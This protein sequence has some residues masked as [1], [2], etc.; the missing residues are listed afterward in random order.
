MLLSSHW[1]STTSRSFDL[2]A[3]YRSQ[4]KILFRILINETRK[5]EKELVQTVWFIVAQHFSFDS[6]RF[7]IHTRSFQHPKSVPN[8][9]LRHFTAKN[10]RSIR[11]SA[12]CSCT[13]YHSC[14]SRC[15]F[16]C[17]FPFH[18]SLHRKHTHSIAAWCLSCRRLVLCWSLA[19]MHAYIHT[20]GNA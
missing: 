3:L 4:P 20:W 19:V 6:R 18:H 1:H 10:T 9:R 11:A 15:R 12:H 7:L 5:R 2:R 13:D 14:C 8:K 17:V 16:T